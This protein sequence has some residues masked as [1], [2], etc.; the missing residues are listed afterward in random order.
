VISWVSNFA[1]KFNLYR[2]TSA[3][4]RDVLSARASALRGVPHLALGE[5]GTSQEFSLPIA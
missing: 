2:Y 5:A 4:M 3:A 1:F